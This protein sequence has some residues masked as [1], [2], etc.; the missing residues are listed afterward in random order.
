MHAKVPQPDQARALLLR[1]DTDFFR[2]NTLA[3]VG[4]AVV[5]VVAVLLGA[6]IASIAAC[7]L[8]W[9]GCLGRSRKKS[10]KGKMELLEEGASEDG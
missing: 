5:V 7:G 8:D 9:K 10:R 1:R 2:N 3:T 4:F 6:G